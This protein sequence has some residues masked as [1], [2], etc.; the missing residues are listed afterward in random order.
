MAEVKWK[1]VLEPEGRNPG[2]NVEQGKD[3]QNTGGMV[4]YL[5]PDNA[6][7]YGAPPKQ[8]VSRVA[9]IR[10]PAICANPDVPFAEQ[11]RKEIAKA[12]TSVEL[13]NEQLVG[14]GELQ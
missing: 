11:L 3:P 2:P 12:R 1:I 7:G 4:I 5:L 14:S 8:E 13:L 10:D 6:G 9:F